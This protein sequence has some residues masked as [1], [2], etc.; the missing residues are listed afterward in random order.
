[1]AQRF[2]FCGKCI[3]L[4]PALAAEVALYLPGMCF[5]ATSLAMPNCRFSDAELPPN[6]SRLQA[7]QV[8]IG[9]PTPTAGEYFQSCSL[10][11][12]YPLFV[13]CSIAFSMNR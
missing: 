2:Q 10:L 1:V 8:P 4:N 3:I 9:L 12:R 11:N 5:S 13:S 7:L 6:Q